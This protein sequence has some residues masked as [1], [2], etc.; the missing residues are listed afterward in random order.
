MLYEMFLVSFSYEAYTQFIDILGLKY[1]FIFFR[2]KAIALGLLYITYE[3]DK[4]RPFELNYLYDY[5][6]YW[7]QHQIG[8]HIRF[9]Y[10]ILSNGNMYV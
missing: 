7:F 5:S 10:I 3:K 2:N 8:I 4:P 6:I 1:V 9:N